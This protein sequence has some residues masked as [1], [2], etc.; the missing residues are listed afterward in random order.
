MAIT[1]LRS[2]YCMLYIDVC[3]PVIIVA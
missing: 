2:C 1:L 3:T